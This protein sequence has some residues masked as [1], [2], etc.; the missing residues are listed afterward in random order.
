MNTFKKILSGDKKFLIMT[1]VI[2]ALGILFLASASSVPGYSIHQDSYFFVKRQIFWILLGAVAF[3]ITAIKP[4]GS[5]RNWA[6]WALFGSFVLLIM[7]FIPGLRA[8]FGTSRSWIQLGSSF[9]V[10]QPSEIVKLSF[11]IYLSAWLDS[12]R[13]LA[14]DLKE[15][16]I[17]F[18]VVLGTI[19]L[20]LLLEPDT[21]SVVII[22]GIALGA[23]FLSGAHLKIFLTTI[24]VGLFALLILMQFS[25]YRANRI[26]TFLDSS[27]DPQGAGYQIQQSLIA[28]GSGG[29]FGEGLGKSLQKHLFLPRTEDDSIFSVIGEEMGF[30]VTAGFLLLL[31]FWL[32]RAYRIAALA[33]P[34][35]ERNLVM[36][37]VIWLSFQTFINVGAMLSLV[38]MTGVTLP[39]ISYGGS[40]MLINLTALGMIYN[41]SRHH[42]LE[43]VLGNRG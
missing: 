5:W 18:F 37:I 6:G 33:P 8:E 17:P 3:L 1:I 24:G 12:R 23:Y 30:F 16:I 39:L 35:F 42:P 43:K 9:F 27:R 31:M 26:L 36:G 11:L 13:K 10:F 29:L 2:L 40:S 4:L 38:P 20:L 21:G 19:V 41:V 34:G 28:I 22:G 25:S 15:G 32:L 7:V 14:H